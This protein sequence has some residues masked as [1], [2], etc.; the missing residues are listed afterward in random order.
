MY[1][2]EGFYDF[3]SVS[4]YRS[5]HNATKALLGNRL[6]LGYAYFSAHFIYHGLSLMRQIPK[7]RRLVPLLERYVL[8]TLDLPDARWRL[9][10]VFDAIT[11]FYASTHTGE[12]VR[13][14]FSRSNCLHLNA[15]PWGATTF[16]GIKGKAQ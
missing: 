9:L 15:Q 12:E 8:V 16:V 10:D 14:W 1:Q 13:S 7:V 2:K 5:I 4:T 11:P 6:A 3:P